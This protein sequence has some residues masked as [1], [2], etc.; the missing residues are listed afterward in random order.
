MAYIEAKDIHKTFGKGDAAV[1]ALRGVSLSVDKGEMV[2][3]MGKSGSGKSTLLNILGGLMTMDEGEL[4]VGG[5]KVDFRK[6]K[7]LLNYRRREVGFVVQY[8]ALIDDMNVYKNVSLPLRY[9]GIPRAKIKQRTTKMLRHLGIEEKAKAYPSELSGGQ[10]QRAAIAR[11]L[12]KN[13]RIILADEP[14]GALDEGT[15]DDVMKLFQRLKKKDRAIIIVTHDNKVAE[16]CDRVV[17]LRDGMNA[18]RD[19]Q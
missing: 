8:F 15:G 9:Q 12:V 17:Y 13:A 10:Q 4:Y 3:V 5:K 6:K 1:H 18:R 16:Y 14:T 2:A 19:I 7:Y 11:A